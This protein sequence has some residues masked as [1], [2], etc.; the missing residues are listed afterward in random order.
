MRES[1]QKPM[2]GIVIFLA[3]ALLIGTYGC[4]EP[5][6]DPPEFRPIVFVHGMAGSADQFELQALRFASNGYKADII[7]GYEYNT[8]G[9]GALLASIADAANMPLFTMLFRLLGVSAVTSDLDDHIDA[10][11]AES[12]AKQ[13]ELVGHSLG[14]MVSS[15]YLSDPQHA[16]KVAHYVNVD[17]TPAAA[18]PGGVPTLA[19]WAENGILAGGDSPREIT[20]AKN[21]LLSNQTHVQASTSRESFVEMYE[22]FQGE[23]PATTDVLPENSEN[24]VLAGRAVNFIRNDVPAN[25]TFELYEI[26]SNT[27]LRKSDTPLHTQPIGSD[28]RFQYDAAKAGVYYEF[29]VY[30]ADRSISQHFY[31]EPYIRSDYLIR[32]KSSPEGTALA[33][34]EEKSD[35]Q[36]NLTIIRNKEFLGGQ[37]SIKVDGVEVCTEA[38]SPASAS[39]IGLSVIDAGTDGQSDLTQGL[40]SFSTIP[41]V[42][43]VDYFIP[44]EPP[45]KVITVAVKSRM[46]D[47]AEQVIYV[48]NFKSTQGR[49]SIQFSDD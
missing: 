6:P 35:N 41:F 27:G 49:V 29:Y 19:L 36:T 20:G 7:S 17:G 15:L 43:G 13:V 21:V 48:Q 11:L 9:L 12:G 28:G 44:A 16:A 40:E 3:I 39:T 34:L 47:R 30:T 31:Y 2:V 14:T 23:T 45:L 1:N 33:D 42:S 4:D 8:V 10:V 32:L 24:I 22:F 5:I 46:S 37:D 18:P 38:I 26:D 25:A